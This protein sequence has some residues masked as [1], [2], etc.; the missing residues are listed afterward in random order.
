MSIPPSQLG[1][2]PSEQTTQPDF[3]E[4]TLGAFLLQGHSGWPHIYGAQ[5]DGA[6]INVASSELRFECQ[7]C[8]KQSANSEVSYVRVCLDLMVERD[9]ERHIRHVE[10]LFPSF[11]MEV[12]S[13]PLDDDA[14]ARVR[15]TISET[16]WALDEDSPVDNLLDNVIAPMR[17]YEPL[18][19]AL[20]APPDENSLAA[21]LGQHLEHMI[22]DDAQEKTLAEVTVNGCHVRV[23]AREIA[24]QHNLRASGEVKVV[25]EVEVCCA[26]TGAKQG[27]WK[28]RAS[29][30]KPSMA[31][32]SLPTPQNLSKVQLDDITASWREELKQNISERLEHGKPGK[33]K[34]SEV[35]PELAPCPKQGITK[36]D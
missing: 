21:W 9:G 32:R 3:K 22:C 6:F 29:L 14:A 19:N 5:L 35:L 24:I 12:L 13:T 17:L 26:Q 27:G 15:R 11:I 18:L 25:G 2:T 33:I 28:S 7:H 30:M 16:L 20:I 4:G 1:S 23:R 10:E 31:S 8:T 36:V 34:L